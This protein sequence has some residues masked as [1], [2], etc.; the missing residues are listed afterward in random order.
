MSSK[1][2]YF[3]ITFI[4]INISCCCC[5]CCC[6]RRR[7]CCCRYSSCI[8]CCY[9]YYSHYSILSSISITNHIYFEECAFLTDN[10]IYT[11]SH[12]CGI[13]AAGYFRMLMVSMAHTRNSTIGFIVL[14]RNNPVSESYFVHFRQCTPTLVYVTEQIYCVFFLSTFR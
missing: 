14:K 13:Y 9:R 6:S 1:R 5:C 2:I 3:E 11:E 8:C 10:R 12:L 4:V 7:R